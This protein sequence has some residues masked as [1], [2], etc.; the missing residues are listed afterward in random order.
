M[1]EP[2]SSISVVIIFLEIIVLQSCFDRA[3]ITGLPVDERD[4]EVISPLVINDTIIL[5]E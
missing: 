3:L 5:K 2:I 4:L 1:S